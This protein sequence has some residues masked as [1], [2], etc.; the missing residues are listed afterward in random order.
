M[1]EKYLRPEYNAFP[2]PKYMAKTA[3]VNNNCDHLFYLN[4]WF[5]NDLLGPTITLRKQAVTQIMVRFVKFYIKN[6]L[7]SLQNCH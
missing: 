3:D 1:L 4:Q 7:F 6:M 5:S 2:S